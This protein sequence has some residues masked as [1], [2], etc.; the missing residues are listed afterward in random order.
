[1]PRPWLRRSR[2]GLGYC[3]RDIPPERI[4]DVV[5]FGALGVPKLLQRDELPSKATGSFAQSLSRKPLAP[6]LR[7]EGLG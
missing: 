5:T 4:R 3:P 7:G 6:V 2:R 1:M